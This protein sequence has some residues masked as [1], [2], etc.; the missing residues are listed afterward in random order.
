MKGEKEWNRIIYRQI[1]KDK[2]VMRV[3]S[4]F[5]TLSI[6]DDMFIDSY[7][8]HLYHKTNLLCCQF[9]EIMRAH[10]S[11]ASLMIRSLC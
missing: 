4:N 6:I 8:Y 2:R 9:Q 7:V 10:E 5:M 1:L 11:V 3:F